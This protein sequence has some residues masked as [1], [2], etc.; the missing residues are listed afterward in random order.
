MA[1]CEENPL[2]ADGFSLQMD[3]HAETWCFVISLKTVEQ[4]FE[5]PVN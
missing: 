4:P 2:M 3:G 1:I 5:L